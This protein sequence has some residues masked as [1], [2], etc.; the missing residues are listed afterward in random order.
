MFAF[1]FLT[2]LIIPDCIMSFKNI[3][4]IVTF[5]TL[6]FI[7]LD[8]ILPNTVIIKLR[9]FDGSMINKLNKNELENSNKMSK[10]ITRVNTNI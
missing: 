7:M 6:A 4:F 10:E 3:L 5:I 1:V 9:K 2:M 8:S